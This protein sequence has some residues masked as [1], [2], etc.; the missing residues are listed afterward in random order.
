[1]KKAICILAILCLGFI[2]NAQRQTVFDGE[3]WQDQPLP[4]WESEVRDR[5]ELAGKVSF[6]AQAPMP[7]TF[8]KKD[9]MFEAGEEITGV[10]YSSVQRF[11]G[12]VG[13]DISFYTFLSA[14][15]NP[16]SS[17]YLVNYHLPP[18]D[19][20]KAGPFY[21]TVCNTTVAYV[22]G[23]PLLIRARYIRLGESHFLDDIGNDPDSIQLYDSYCNGG[24][25]AHIV[26]ISGIGRDR[27][28][29]VQQIQIFEATG[30]CNRFKTYTREQFIEKQLKKN[31]GHFYRFDHEKWGRLTSLPPYM[32]NGPAVDYRFSK[33]LSPE[34]GEKCTYT[35][36]D[37]VRVDI[38]SGGYKTLELSLNGKHF[39]SYSLEGKKIVALTELPCGIYGASLKKGKKQ[40]AKVEFEVA[41]KACKAWYEGGQLY[42]GGIREGCSPIG[43]YYQ[44]PEIKGYYLRAH[45]CT[46]DGEGRWKVLPNIPQGS[47][48]ELRVNLAGWFGGY[49]A[50]FI[51]L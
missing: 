11:C 9:A 8:H 23:L 4:G 44:D 49:W 26:L 10:P 40:S 12:I 38:L 45:I 34:R 37:T 51:K 25:S 22:W 2:A 16:R 36:G 35:L 31:D 32:E 21:G 13:K 41:S 24:K 46:P 15:D 30:P 18:W 42:I 1:M 48:S 7:K 5:V 14:V 3:F 20:Q 43:A 50:D 6:T 28:G 47:V 29:K 39:S 27:E 17:M 19:M 33:V